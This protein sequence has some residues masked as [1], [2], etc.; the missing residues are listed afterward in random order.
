VTIL[1]RCVVLALAILGGCTQLGPADFASVDRWLHC[2]DCMNGERQAVASRGN[3]IVPLMRQILLFM[4]SV[5]EQTIVRRQATLEYL[6]LSPPGVTQTQYVERA[7]ANYL[8]RRQT[9]AAL[10]LT[11]IHTNRARAALAEAIDPLVLVQYRADVAQTLRYLYAIW[12]TSPFMGTVVNRTPQFGDSVIVVRRPASPQFSAQAIALIDS[13]PFAASSLLYLRRPDTLI[14]AAVATAGIHSVSII[15]SIATAEAQAFRISIASQTDRND[16]A[17]RTCTTMD[18]M[19]DSAEA[20]TPAQ[21]P[22]LRFQSLTTAKTTVDTVDMFKFTAT[23]SPLALTARL[24]WSSP[25]PVNLNLQWRTCPTFLPT[26]NSDGNTPANKPEVTSVL[27]PA[28]QCW[29]LLVTG[30]T[31]AGI[32]SV[33][34]RLRVTSP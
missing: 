2:D 5:D 18:C 17:S 9:R 20:V 33:F 19:I 28:G 31:Q 25:A 13:A 8:A 10:S 34:A 14:F 30:P 21:L 15:D 27:I 11:D 7:F 1:S 22:I 24:D 6:R 29:L 12:T 26:G 3:N 4:P 16:R 23:G 32:Q